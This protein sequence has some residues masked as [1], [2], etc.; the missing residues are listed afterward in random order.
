MKGFT[1]SK[2]K[3]KLASNEFCL[4]GSVW[5]FI[6]NTLFCIYATSV[7]EIG[8]SNCGP[9]SKLDFT[10]LETNFLVYILCTSY[11]IIR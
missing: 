9:F 1:N 5:C 8:K 3:L 10:R 4:R 2:T 7:K 11:R 6:V